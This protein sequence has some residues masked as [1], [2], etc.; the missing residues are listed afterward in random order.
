MLA[1]AVCSVPSPARRG[2]ADSRVPKP[3]VVGS[4]VAV[5]WSNGRSG[6]SEKNPDAVLESHGSAGCR[7]GPLLR[8]DLIRSLYRKLL[9][10]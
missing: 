4:H 9:P 2:D 6:W 7:G 3:V 1:A 10:L 8:E 5:R